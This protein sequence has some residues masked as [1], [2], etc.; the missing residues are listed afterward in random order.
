ML[1]YVAERAWDAR[2]PDAPMPRLEA[3]PTWTMIEVSFVLFCSRDPDFSVW[4]SHANAA[5]A[6]R[7]LDEKKNLSK[8]ESQLIEEK[9]WLSDEVPLFPV[10]IR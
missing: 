10:L 7:K 9:R 1:L 5:G 4:Q 8:D 2:D 3:V 6:D